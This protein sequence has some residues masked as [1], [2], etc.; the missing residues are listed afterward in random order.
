[1]IHRERRDRAARLLAQLR[2]AP[3]VLRRC[4]AEPIAHAVEL[5]ER[6][7][8]VERGEPHAGPSFLRQLDL[9]LVQANR[10]VDVEVRAGENGQVR[11]PGIAPQVVGRLDA[12]RI[13]VSAGEVE[14]YRLAAAV[15]A[16]VVRLRLAGLEEVEARLVEGVH[17]IPPLD[18]PSRVA[19]V[20]PADALLCVG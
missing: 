9:L 3:V 2:G 8:A 16:D 4:A 11:I 7:L 14:A 20:V 19:A 18:L 17:G 6:R 12:G 5:S 10:G 15:R 13:L 1:M